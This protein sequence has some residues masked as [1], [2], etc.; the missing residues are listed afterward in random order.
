MSASLTVSRSPGQPACLRVQNH[1]DTIYKYSF[2]REDELT[3]GVEQTQTNAAGP[4]TI[5][6]I[7]PSSVL[8]LSSLAFGQKAG[9]CVGKI[10]QTK[11]YFFIV[12]IYF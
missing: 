11:K 5:M 1:F 8:F 10:L 3:V 12:F 9:R 7:T 6:F 2:L 4:H